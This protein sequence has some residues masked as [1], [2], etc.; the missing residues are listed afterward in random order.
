MMLKTGV[1]TRL[2]WGVKREGTEDGNLGQ[3]LSGAAEGEEPARKFVQ[4]ERRQWG[5]R[6]G[7]AKSRAGINSVKERRAARQEKDRCH[8]WSNK[9]VLHG[10]YSR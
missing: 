1:W 7:I 9:E 10:S 5:R 6:S 4:P 2:G 3:R 8:Y